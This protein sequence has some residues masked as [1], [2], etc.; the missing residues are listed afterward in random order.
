MIWLYGFMCF[1]WTCKS[2]DNTWTCLNSRLYYI[3]F[4]W[5]EYRQNTM[6][7]Y[8]SRFSLS[9]QLFVWGLMSYFHYLC[10]MAHS[11]VT[12]I[13]CCVFVLFFFI[14]LFMLPVSLDSPILIAPSGFCK[15]Y[16]IS[17]YYLRLYH[18]SHRSNIVSVF[19][20][21]IYLIT[22]IFPSNIKIKVRLRWN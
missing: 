13:L 12:H 17:I 3:V 9:V 6:V 1:V 15:V 7:T 11:G 18:S 20:V 14:L 16:Y 5:L 4:L 8:V 21:Q 22:Y 19:F 2:K 10:L